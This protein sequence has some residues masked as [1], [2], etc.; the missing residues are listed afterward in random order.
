[1]AFAAAG[2]RD[3]VRR[4]LVTLERRAG[5]DDLNGRLTRDIGLPLAQAIFASVEH[6]AAKAVSLLLPIRSRTHVIGGSH[7][8]RDIF[9]L[10]CIEAAL[11][12]GQGRLARA[13]AGTAGRR[14]GSSG[15]ARARA[16]AP[17][18]RLIKGDAPHLIS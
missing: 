13:L 5:D 16:T 9:Q 7:A 17:R 3:Q 11:R 15:D 8:Q 10:T 18:R 14:A 12:A 6:K 1:M 2:R 4:I